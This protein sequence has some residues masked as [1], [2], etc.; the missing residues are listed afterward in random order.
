[1]DWQQTFCRQSYYA[2]LDDSEMDSIMR[3]V[4]EMCAVDCQDKNGKWALMYVRLRFVAV[5][6][7][8][9]I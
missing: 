7:K 3:E 6:D 4:Q 1:M 8:Y 2:D 5:L 9:D